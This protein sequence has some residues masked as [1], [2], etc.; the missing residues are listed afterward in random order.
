[1]DE[2]PGKLIVSWGNSSCFVDV[3]MVLLLTIFAAVD[4][5]FL[6][7]MPRTA[8]GQELLGLLISPN[9]SEMKTRVSELLTRVSEQQGHENLLDALFAIFADLTSL[10]YS[11]PHLCSL[12]DPGKGG[13]AG[14]PTSCTKCSS[15]LKDVKHPPVVCFSVHD[16]SPLEPVVHV[17]ESVYKLVSALYCIKGVYHQTFQHHCCWYRHDA[18]RQ[19]A[20]PKHAKF[21]QESKHLAAQVFV[22]VDRLVVST[23]TPLLRSDLENTLSRDL[24][25]DIQVV[26]AALTKFVRN[27]WRVQPP[28]QFNPLEQGAVVAHVDQVKGHMFLIGRLESIV[29][30]YNTYD[31]QAPSSYVAVLQPLLVSEV[32]KVYIIRAHKQPGINSCGL[33]TANA[34]NHIMGEFP[35]L[36][37][38][39]KA[40]LDI[41]ED[42]RPCVPDLKRHLL[43]VLLPGAGKVLPASN[44]NGSNKN[45]Y[46][47]AFRSS[48]KKTQELS[49]SPQSGDEPAVQSWCI[50]GKSYKSYKSLQCSEQVPLLHCRSCRNRIVCS[51]CQT[52]VV[53]ASFTQYLNVE[54]ATKAAFQCPDCG[55]EFEQCDWCMAPVCSTDCMRDL[56]YRRDD[57]LNPAQTCKGCLI[58][59]EL[60]P[61][62]EG[63]I[64]KKSRKE[65]AD[66]VRLNRSLKNRGLSLRREC[67]REDQILMYNTYSC[68][69]RLSLQNLRKDL[70]ETGMHVFTDITIENLAD[71]YLQ[72]K[73]EDD[74][75]HEQKTGA[76][77]KQ[78][79]NERHATPALKEF[80]LLAGRLLAAV[81]A[82]RQPFGTAW[83]ANPTTLSVFNPGPFAHVQF[84]G[85]AFWLCYALEPGTYSTVS[86][87]SL[88]PALTSCGP[89]S[90]STKSH[91]EISNLVLRAPQLNTDVTPLEMKADQFFVCAA[92][93]P[94]KWHTG[95]KR[96]QIAMAP[97]SKSSIQDLLYAPGKPKANCLPLS[98]IPTDTVKVFTEVNDQRPC[99]MCSK[100][101]PVYLDEVMC[102]GCCKNMK[103]TRS[104]IQRA[105][106]QKAQRQ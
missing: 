59:H 72:L 14:W 97:Q 3:L 30:V 37:A 104:Q 7:P 94:V 18:N 25:L 44:R 11:C 98:I 61:A 2:K 20:I 4:L 48:Q 15:Y 26:N 52:S 89:T 77:F 46:S 8:K 60:C 87:K 90:L 47:Y 31:M 58:S 33:T 95:G 34:A 16:G 40:I 76:S 100:L 82:L 106:A 73:L 41:L 24:Y 69:E 27:G 79:G 51:N 1:M 96:L 70:E 101:C 91:R 5:Q 86:P 103:R 6:S 21:P 13:F 38:N 17:G 9:S 57:Y 74:C 42:L 53:L 68:I 23:V 83:E 65:W 12:K 35:P 43:S 80:S 55:T 66:Y 75:Y 32:A 99:P 105:G 63:L 22:R 81:S 92:S 62:C 88:T 67:E 84:P 10:H 56:P 29:F 39:W 64:H 19:A 28:G 78:I 45:I 71:D 50:C 85:P 36:D 102:A 93:A 54:D 49:I